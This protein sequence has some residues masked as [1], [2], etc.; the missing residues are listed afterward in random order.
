MQARPNQPFEQRT[1]S[2][3]GLAA[4]LVEVVHPVEHAVETG[5]IGPLEGAAAES[6][7]ELERKIDLGRLRIAESVDVDELDDPEA[8][9]NELRERLAQS[10]EEVRQSRYADAVR[11]RYLR[12]LESDNV[13]FGW[14]P[15]TLV[16]DSPDKG[17][18]GKAEESELITAPLIE[19]LRTAEK[20]L[21]VV[22]PYFVPTKRGVES[23]KN[24]QNRGVDVTVITNS[25]AANNQFTVH[26]G[27][28]PS[29]KPLLE[30]GVKIY[31]V[32]PDAD[33][34]G[35]EFID[36][37]GATATLH[38]KAFM[39]DEKDVF[40]GSFNFDPRSANLNTELG[41]IIRD[42]ELAAR[43]G[44]RVDG[45]LKDQ[46]FEVFLNEDGKLRWR[47]YRD[48]EEIIYDK[49]PETTWG[50]RFM[51]GFARIIPKSQL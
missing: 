39:V 45:R 40:I 1:R 50:Q 14:A 42:P 16:V 31:E 27:Y 2:E 51:A 26:G 29:R 8:V 37:S 34:A 12:Y 19:E 38:T 21:L 20:E 48:G 35:T 10:L 43:Y 3:S 23:L 9:L 17:I 46:T 13:L 47:G 32:R 7:A 49:E 18:K 36:T 33:V 41:V 44:E 5:A 30:A 22:S 4:L 15:Y 25:L 24:L 11:E 6:V 28:S